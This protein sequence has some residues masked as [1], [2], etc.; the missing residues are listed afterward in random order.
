MQRLADQANIVSKLSALGTF[1]HRND[2]AHIADVVHETVGIFG[3]DRCLFGS[4]FPIEKLW[5][6]YSDLVVAY[7]NAVSN[8]QPKEQL[9]V[10]HDNT[11]RVYKLDA[12]AGA[13][14]GK[15]LT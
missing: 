9:A 12:I 6:N 14:R 1:I 11:N 10:L 5:T 4:N 7:R 15:G 13:Q 3:T 2:A 8:Y